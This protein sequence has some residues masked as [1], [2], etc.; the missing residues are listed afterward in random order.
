MARRALEGITVALG[1][2]RGTLA[3]RLKALR[4]RG[5]IEGRMLD[6]ADSL[7]EVGND[8]A[9]QPGRRI[10]QDDARDL[11][12]FVEALADYAF[13]YRARYE[14]FKERRQSDPVEG[15]M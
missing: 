3:A 14:R 7:R 12:Q 1:E 6:W 10:S 13:T 5:E 15:S 8:A 9:H 2:K 4:A 11:L